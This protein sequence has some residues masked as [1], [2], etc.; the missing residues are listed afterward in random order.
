[1]TLFRLAVNSLAW[2]AL[3]SLGP[4]GSAYAQAGKNGA[5]TLN[6]SGFVVNSYAPLTANAAVGN[7]SVSVSSTA[8][9]SVGDLVL[10]IQMQGAQINSTNTA[11]YGE[12][13]NLRGAGI[14]EL[15]V[16]QALTATTL[17]L[18]QPLSN[19]YT[20]ADKAQVVR[21]P[22][23]TT[24]TIN[25]AGSVTGQAWNGSS[26]GIVAIE[27]QGTITVNGS[28]TAT[29]QGFRGGA[30]ADNTINNN[31]NYL[32]TG[33]TGGEKG[34]GIAGYGSSYPGGSRGRGAA[35]NGGGGGNS[36]NAGGGGGANGGDPASWTGTG[37]PSVATAAWAA[38][39]NLEA[40][41]L[42]GS[43]STGGG[44]GGYGVS[45]VN[46]DALTVGPNQ[47]AWG[48]YQ[49][50]NTGGI[51]GRPL[52]YSSGRL[53]LGGGGGSGDG[54]TN[55]A[56]VGGRGGGLIY[57]ISPTI[58]GS[59]TIVA[60]GTAGGTS[61]ANDPYADGAGGGGAGGTIVLAAG[62]VSNLRVQANGGT[63][64]NT[65]NTVDKGYGPGGGGGAGYIGLSSTATVSGATFSLSGGSSGVSTSPGLTEFPPNGATDGG[66]SA[67]ALR[68]ALVVP[69]PV[70]WTQFG[71]GYASGRVRLS[72]TTAQEKNN[73]YFQPERSLDGLTFTACGERV[74]GAGSST[75]P[76]SYAA[77]DA[78]PPRGTVYYRVRQVDAD[79]Q[80]ATTAAVAV[81]C[82][83]TTGLDAYPNPVRRGQL[84]RTHLP[85]GTAVQLTDLLGRRVAAP[86]TALDG[87]LAVDTRR[88]PAGQYWLR[89]AGGK[90]LRLVVQD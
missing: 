26:G 89:A 58:T 44:R 65:E 55:V 80:S 37:R 32:G 27:A 82:E 34:E 24:V 1:M 63:G 11:A 18:S 69:L 50:P 59:G 87:G 60:D 23:Y 4:L 8:G 2:T 52:D 21:V 46:L 43:S 66:L 56:G 28:I 75:S 57:L 19:A 77:S 17:R 3:L 40:P 45:D 35:A 62:S 86:V 22:R 79:G 48:E 30:F 71:A 85:A 42:A 36:V 51:G 12:V 49:R 16:V 7:T 9:M 14:H 29:G 47:A 5:L 88:L 68:P 15:A 83:E 78:Q 38:A 20:L 13:T 81:R 76:R 39:W 74:A 67:V 90:P 61:F 53:F 54:N 84:L 70:S 25:A 31:A 6:G 73:A 64:G 72:W 41:G 33:N 10:I